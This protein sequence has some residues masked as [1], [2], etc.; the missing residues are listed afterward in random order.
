MVLV[1]GG[2]RGGSVGRTALSEGNDAPPMIEFINSVAG[3]LT[4][5]TAFVIALTPPLARL[6]K[7]LLD[8]KHRKS[9]GHKPPGHDRPKSRRSRIVVNISITVT[10][11]FAGLGILVGR[12]VP[13]VFGAQ[14]ARQ[15]MLVKAFH[16]LEAERWEEAVRKSD[17]VIAQFAGSAAVEEETLARAQMVQP[18]TGKVA[19]E[20]RDGI[21]V[22]GVLNDVAASY[23][24]R[25]RAL[26][27]L[28]RI[29]EARRA[30][31]EAAKLSYGRT[32]DPRDE[33]FWSPAEGALG[34]LRTLPPGR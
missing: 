6:G 10:F 16:A 25:G 13:G 3:L 11:G 1:A 19:K 7:W 34:R 17:E 9:S 28:G 5:I 14:V 31:E 4:A 29:G 30:Y 23:F 18:P 12:A 20:Q 21:F 22:R 26:E 32:Y 2:K 27:Q 15:V 8:R 33:S 24:I